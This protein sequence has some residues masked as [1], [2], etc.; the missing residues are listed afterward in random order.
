[1]LVG[2]AL[3]PATGAAAQAWK[4]Q[5][6]FTADDGVP[7]FFGESVAIYG[8]TA[9]VVDSADDD[10]AIGGGAAYVFRFDGSA[11]LQ[12]AKLLAADGGHLTGLVGV[13]PSRVAQLLSR[14]HNA[15]PLARPEPW[16]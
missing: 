10:S 11:W 3:P 1:M 12:E 13:L 8:G 2:A 7:G 6:K 16:S 5:A 9:I 4:Q 15:I 14:L